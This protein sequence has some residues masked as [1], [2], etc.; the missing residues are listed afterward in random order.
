MHQNKNLFLDSRWAWGRDV[1][2]KG[3]NTITGLTARSLSSQWVMGRNWDVALGIKQVLPSHRG[4]WKGSCH[5]EYLPYLLSSSPE[6]NVGIFP[7][8]KRV[9]RRTDVKKEIEHRLSIIF[10]FKGTGTTV[11]TCKYAMVS[12]FRLL[13]ANNLQ[14][15]SLWKLYVPLVKTLSLQ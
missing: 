7:F 13:T 14:L 2:P 3:E 1:P 12:A 11:N 9:F 10:S 5:A 4:W 15:D 8:F 6:R